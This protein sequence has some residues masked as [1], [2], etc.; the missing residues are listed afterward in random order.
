MQLLLEPFNRNSETCH[1]L[2][3]NPRMRL[4]DM[5]GLWTRSVLQSFCLAGIPRRCRCALEWPNH[6]LFLILE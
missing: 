1:P 5:H 3:E 4:R 6:H 2:S